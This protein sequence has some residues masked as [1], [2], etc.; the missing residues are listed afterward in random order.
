[1]L[2]RCLFVLLASLTPGVLLADPAIDS[3]VQLSGRWDRRR[4]DRVITV[5]SGSY[6]IAR[7]EGRS[8]TAR[9]DLTRN[10]PPVPTIAWKFDND[11]QWR[12]S[13]IA[14]SVELGK[15]LKPGPHTVWLVVRGLDEHQPRWA[16][17]LTA[18]VTFLGF[19]LSESGK[20]LD[21]PPE[22]KLKI[23][24]LG[25]SITEGV[26]V[27]KKQPSRET[28]AWQTDGLQAWPAQTALRLG[29]QW[30]QVG[31]GAVGVTKSGS[32]GVPPAPDSFNWFYEGCPR[33]DWQPTLVVINHGTNDRNASSEQFRAAY[34]NYLARIRK[35]YPEAKILTLRPFAGTH[36][37]DIRAEVKAR[38]D[39]GDKRIAF[40]DTTG[41]VD[42]D[43]FTDGVHPN[44]GAGPKVA[45]K[46]SK[47]IKEENAKD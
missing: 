9:F 14:A 47:L 39:M 37:D 13:E 7:F 41:W 23:E 10:K 28:W 45:E 36:A 11:A 46:L 3:K 26:L 6:V 43:D 32:G 31:F 24:F 1:M 38:N 4:P 44:A 25:D 21:P 42:R 27:H 15:D 35:A 40:I 18:S 16:E 8:I 2:R 12:E 20:F 30:R 5:N 19:E 29:A 17:P 22:P 34:A 33:D